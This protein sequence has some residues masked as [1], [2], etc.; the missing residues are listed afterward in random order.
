M[1]D[2][3]ILNFHSNKTAFGYN[4]ASKVSNKHIFKIWRKKRSEFFKFL[5]HSTA[6]TYGESSVHP[7]F[8][9][10]L[11]PFHSTEIST[12]GSTKAWREKLYTW[13]CVS[14]RLSSCGNNKIQGPKTNY[15]FVIVITYI[16]AKWTVVCCRTEPNVT[17]CSESIR[18][19]QW[20]TR[21]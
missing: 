18:C 16:H 5:D 7:T 1:V 15:W 2:R 19:G 11:R 6:L 8:A 14:H 12:A 20:Q 17:T 4:F 21:S 10:K 13:S 3:E 9:F